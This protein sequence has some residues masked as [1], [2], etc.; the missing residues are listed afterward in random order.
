MIINKNSPIPQYFQLQTW[1]KEQIEQGDFKENDKILTEEEFAKITGLARPTIRQAIQNLVNEGYL[2]R[3]R[4]LGTFVLKQTFESNRQNIVGVLV[5]FIGSGYAYELLRGSGDEAAR[6]NFSIIL[7]NTDDSYIMANLHADRFIEHNVSGIIFVPTAASDEK[8]RLIV[9]KFL[10]KKIPVVIADRQIP[11]LE[12][13]NVITDNFNGAYNITKYL[14][15]NGHRRIAITISTAMNTA[16]ERL[17]G[18]KKALSDAN[19]PIDP[20]LVFTSNERFNE[21]LCIEYAKIILAPKQKISAIFAGDDRTAYLIHSVAQ[22]MGVKIPEDISLV[23]YDDF[24]INGSYALE[25][26]TVHQPIREMGQKCMELLLARIQ[27]RTE[28]PQQIIL[29]SF[30]SEKR[31]VLLI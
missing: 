21:E 3:K 24:P 17:A 1:I 19:I 14:I 26:T 30:L 31:S 13:D 2:V 29:K 10:R 23:G 27:G 9:E 28:P 18:Y 7:G 11:D 22:K 25:L 16:R 8:N 15:T 6:N 12:I 5:N 4:G 20:A